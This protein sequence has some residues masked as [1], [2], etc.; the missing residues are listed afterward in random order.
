MDWEKSMR[1][2]IESGEKLENV[3]QAITD[4]ANKID[5]E[6][7]DTIRFSG[8]LSNEGKDFANEI[9]KLPLSGYNMAIIWLHYMETQLP[10]YVE[11]AKKNCHCDNLIM[12]TVDTLG[13]MV[14]SNQLL[15]EGDLVGW[16]DRLAKVVTSDGV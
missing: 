4:A 9:L 15:M 1:E 10:G 11:W 3:M 5:K 6:T 16:F 14:K 7:R 13:G 8:P 2:A 12:A